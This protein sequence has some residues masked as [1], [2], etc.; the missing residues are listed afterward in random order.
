M[1]ACGRPKGILPQ[2]KMEAVLWDVA[3]GSDFVN[4]N[5]YYKYPQLNRAAVNQEVLNKIFSLHKVTKKEFF[6]SLDYYQQRP[7]VYIAMLDSIKSRQ[8]KEQGLRPNT[9][10]S[11]RA[12][13]A[14]K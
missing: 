5:I 3:K 9:S 13:Q 10:D 6:N 12:A 1:T 4:S 8:T 14:I 2:D 11:A 7:D